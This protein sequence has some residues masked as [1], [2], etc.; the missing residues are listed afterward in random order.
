MKRFRNY[1]QRTYETPDGVKLR[2]HSRGV[3]LVDR[4]EERVRQSALQVLANEYG[5]PAESLLAEVPVAR[6]TPN[7]GRADI[8]VELP[9]KHADGHAVVS[10][11]A[12]AQ[13]SEVAY[14]DAVRGVRSAL[15]SC[16]PCAKCI[17]IVVDDVQLTDLVDG[18]KVPA[19]PL[20]FTRDRGGMTLV[21]SASRN[22][23]ERLPTHLVYRVLGYGMTG[24]EEALA[25]ELALPQWAFRSG[26][27]VAFEELTRSVLQPLGLDFGSGLSTTGDDG[28]GVLYPTATSWLGVLVRADLKSESW[29]EVTMRSMEDGPTWRATDGRIVVRA[30]LEG[31]S[32]GMR[33]LVSFMLME[34]HDD[35]DAY[36]TLI[37]RSED[38][39]QVR[40]DD[41]R[42]V[43]ATR[44]LEGDRPWLAGVV[45]PDT[46]QSGSKSSERLDT[47]FVVVECKAPTVPLTDEVL[48]QGLGY[49]NARE[50]TYLVLVNGNETR[51]YWLGS[52]RPQ[53]IVDI[54][55]FEEAVSG[56]AFKVGVPSPREAPRPL[57]DDA[58]ER[59]DM[60]RLHA[61]ARGMG[62]DVAVRWW[63]PILRLEDIL[64]DP[65]SVEAPAEG[66]GVRIV[67]DLG[68]CLHAAD[69]A[70]GK[71]AGDYRDLLVK[72]AV[73]H[74]RVIGL[75]VG[76]NAKLVEH[77]RWGN[78]RGGARFRVGTADGSK[79]RLVTTM[80]LERHLKIV[81][82]RI[83]M[84]HDGRVSVKKSRATKAGLLQHVGRSCPDLVRDG[85]VQL[86][87]VALRGPRERG[88]VLDWLLRVCSYAVLREQYKAAA[89]SRKG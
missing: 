88:D 26:A 33:V 62:P 21:A 13:A 28:Y 6:K 32:K 35:D 66:Y 19:S 8:L 76:H 83:Y 89:G 17:Q 63:G 72:D 86:G 49:A 11:E 36:G 67:E 29:T 18:A 20:G 75:A 37:S 55:T 85:K 60:I 4:P 54:P 53:E 2:G 23:G 44:W 41:G 81:G 87:S 52:G 74:E 78:V 22:L 40:L 80:D 79:Y 16:E 25:K 77:P 31:L 48:R 9:R 10:T 27:S 5:Y 50:A 57:P 42:Q 58:V 84:W 43:E 71:A 59:G 46:T 38:S 69:T 34:D 64:L 70:G 73:G 82:D 7:R 15:D 51:S 65:A 3:F 56:Q 14:R 61:R 12:P 45:D 39:Y 1:A 47:T 24:R 68:L 30:G